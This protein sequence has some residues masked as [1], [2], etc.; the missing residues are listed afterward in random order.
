MQV[1]I[2]CGGKGERL[3]EYTGRVPKPMVEI[4]GR[5]VLWHVMKMYAYAGYS[6]FILCLGH[7]AEVIRRFIIGLAENA[8]SELGRDPEHPAG[9]EV[10]RCEDGWT[11]RLVDTGQHTMTGG[12]LRRIGQL[13]EG[14]VFHA[15]YADAVSDVDL[16]A[17]VAF[18]ESRRRLGTVTVVKPPPRFGVVRLA[19]DRVVSF[20]EKMPA[21]E[22]WIN[23]GFFV[24]HRRLFERLHDDDTVLE[25]EP[26][27]ELA[28][29]NELSAFVHNGFWQCMD[30]MSDVLRLNAQWREGDRPWARWVNVVIPRARAA[31]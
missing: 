6:D 12:R 27:A 1:V 2:L 4:G 31:G 17:L 3:R 29:S 13:L 22:P 14:D 20:A 5:P 21:D 28:T 25:Q 7:K 19:G 24:F 15:A 30:T 26:L 9:V 23:G 11:V 18:H 8:P 10:V 16:R